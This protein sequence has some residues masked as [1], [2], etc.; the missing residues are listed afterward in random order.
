[1]FESVS[2]VVSISVYTFPNNVNIYVVYSR[3][4]VISGLLW[5]FVQYTQRRLK[6]DGIKEWV[7]SFHV[8]YHFTTGILV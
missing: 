7:L 8:N 4:N 1:M 2:L 6:V 5:I 3:R